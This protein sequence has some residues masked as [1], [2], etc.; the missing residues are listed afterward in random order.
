MISAATALT[1]AAGIASA[2]V[3]PSF[4]WVQVD[5]TVGNPGGDAINGAAW[6]AN[7]WVTYDLFMTYDGLVNGV[8]LGSTDDP[9]EAGLG[10]S[11]DTAVFN[12]S[13]F[14]ASDFESA[15]Q[16]SFSASLYDTYVTLGSNNPGGTAS[17]QLLGIALAGL[18]PNANGVL[19]GAWAQNPPSGGTAQDATDGIRLLRI[20]FDGDALGG[21]G[22]GIGSGDIQVGLSTGI[23]TARVGAIPTPGAAALLGLGGIA[24]IR[25]RR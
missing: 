5:N 25:R 20:S 4:E 14:V 17:T 22:N 23:I 18:V 9:A 15:A 13:G 6:S 19:R 24:A 12:T 1:L 7:N 10:L 2:G 16:G 8:N 21:R 3:A 11:F